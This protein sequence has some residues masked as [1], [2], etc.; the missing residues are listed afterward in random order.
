MVVSGVARVTNGGET[1]LLSE[2]ESTYI[3]KGVVHCLEN[4][5]EAPLEIIE[6]QSGSYLGEDD[7][8]RLSDQYGRN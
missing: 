3:P 7:I 1:F 5:G 2:N 4:P 8:V 6:I